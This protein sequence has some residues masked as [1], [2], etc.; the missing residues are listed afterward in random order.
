MSDRR[1]TLA[2]ITHQAISVLNRELG[3]VDT[4]RFIKQYT[5][6]FGDYPA[7]RDALLGDVTLDELLK[8]I[9]SKPPESA[10]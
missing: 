7:E 10:A 5:N 4:I 8:D 6:G 9:R 3:A 1:K 2:E